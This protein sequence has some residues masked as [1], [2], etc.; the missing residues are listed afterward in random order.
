MSTF[1]PVFLVILISFR[2]YKDCFC[3]LLCHFNQASSPYTGLLTEHLLLMVLILHL[4]F[5]QQ[6]LDV[7]D[8]IYTDLMG[9]NLT[10]RA[11]SNNLYYQFLE[12]GPV[13][14]TL[15]VG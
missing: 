10:V 9:T 15:L 4:Y 11:N 1:I 3:I 5:R 2:G 14:N 13:A 8:W 12:S 7:V 6:Y